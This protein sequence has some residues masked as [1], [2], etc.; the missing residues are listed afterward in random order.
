MFSSGYSKIEFSVRLVLKL[1]SLKTEF[2]VKNY[3]L[4]KII[5]ENKIFSFRTIVSLKTVCQ[6][7]EIKRKLDKML[8][9][10]LEFFQP[11]GLCFSAG[12]LR[13]YNKG[14]T[15]IIDMPIAV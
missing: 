6:R 8:K 13:G 2:A 12:V 4:R 15:V 11:K 14:P 3:F 5:Q 10:K 1:L 7:N 9:E